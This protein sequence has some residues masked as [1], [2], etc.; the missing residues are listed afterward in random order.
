[1][2]TLKN[3]RKTIKRKG[4]ASYP[5]ARYNPRQFAANIAAQANYVRRSGKSVRKSKKRSSKG[6]RSFF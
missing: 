2:P 5:N 3:F 6:G 1:M 4:P